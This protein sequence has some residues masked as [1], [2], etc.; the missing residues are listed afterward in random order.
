M[1]IWRRFK[2]SKTIKKTI[3]KYF[4]DICG[5]ES[6]T[7]SISCPVLFLTDQTEGKPVRPYITYETLDLCDSCLRKVVSVSAIG[8]QGYNTYSFSEPKINCVRERILQETKKSTSVYPFNKH[9]RLV[10]FCVN[11]NDVL[12]NNDE[13]Y[14][15][16][17]NEIIAVVDEDWLFDLISETTDIKPRDYLLNEY[18]SEESSV[19]LEK[20][21]ME[22]HLAIIDFN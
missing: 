11:V 16:D 6:D 20:A 5:K 4:C 21:I 15:A 12:A 10:S 19:W 18:T 9:R 22:K 17:F 13:D 1:T 8:A 3:E 2:R 14:D 7:Q